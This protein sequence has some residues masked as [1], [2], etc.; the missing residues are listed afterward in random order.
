VVSLQM[1]SQ[2]K[3]SKFETLIL[4]QCQ[5]FR[6]P[7]NVIVNESISSARDAG[8]DRLEFGDLSR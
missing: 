8:L 2:S 7:M 1:E 3:N 6:S 5:H 4:L